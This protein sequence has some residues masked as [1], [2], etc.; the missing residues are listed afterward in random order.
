MQ[1]GTHARD[2]HRDRSRRR[3][4]RS[5]PTPARSAAI[6]VK[7]FIGPRAD[8]FAFDVVRFFQVRA[9]LASRFFG[10][11]G[12]NGNAAAALAR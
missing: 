5:P 4:A 8:S 10:G 9:F 1:L 6:D 2:D 11:T 12:G 3:P 7:Y